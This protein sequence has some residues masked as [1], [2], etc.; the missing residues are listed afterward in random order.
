MEAK[1]IIEDPLLFHS[2]LACL[3]QTTYYFLILLREAGIYSKFQC[4]GG[5]SVKKQEPVSS[6]YGIEKAIRRTLGG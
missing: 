3:Y 6:Q 4:R 1:E 2:T 5:C